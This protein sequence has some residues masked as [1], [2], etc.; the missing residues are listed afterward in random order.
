MKNIVHPPFSQVRSDRR[1][2]EKMERNLGSRRRHRRPEPC[3]GRRRPC[4]RCTEQRWRSDGL[5]NF[6]LGDWGTQF[7]MLIEYLFEKF[8]NWQEIGSQAIG[9]LQVGYCYS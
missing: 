5:W 4:S 8:P 9:D 3:R 6:G 1:G 2:S 7:G